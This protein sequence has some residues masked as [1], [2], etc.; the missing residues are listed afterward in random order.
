MCRPNSTPEVLHERRTIFGALI[1]TGLEVGTPDPAGPKGRE[2]RASIIPRKPRSC[3]VWHE[4]YSVLVSLH[5]QEG[6]RGEN[7]FNR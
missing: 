4:R 7:V 1:V 6:S 3:V 2:R 5:A